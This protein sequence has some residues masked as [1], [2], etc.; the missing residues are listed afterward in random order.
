[1]ILYFSATGNCKYVAQR[2]GNAEQTE[3]IS[4]VGCDKIQFFDDKIVIITPTYNWGLPCASDACIIV[5]SLQFN[6]ERI[7]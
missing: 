5:Q 7:R 2:I 3:A 4:I 1:M 6:M